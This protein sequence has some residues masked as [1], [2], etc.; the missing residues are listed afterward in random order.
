MSL[1]VYIGGELVPKDEAKT[2]VFDHGLLYGDGVFEGIRVYGGKVFL[3]D[4]HIARLYE[5]ALAIR[6][7]IPEALYPTA[8]V[9]QKALDYLN[10][11]QHNDD[12]FFAFVSFNDPHHPFNPPGKY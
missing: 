5:G 2:S 10:S 8:Y 12:P 7:P 9:K 3:L 1:K 6:L 11:R 4:E